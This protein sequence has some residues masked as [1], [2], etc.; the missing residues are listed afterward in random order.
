VL[1]LE[2]VF[3]EFLD[4]QDFALQFQRIVAAAAQAVYTPQFSYF[5]LV[6]VRDLH[7]DLLV[8]NKLPSI[9]GSVTPGAATPFYSL[10]SYAASVP[11]LLRQSSALVDAILKGAKPGD[12]PVQLPTI[13]DLAV[14]LDTARK[15]GVTIPTSILAQATLVIDYDIRATK[16]PN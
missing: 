14:N 12:L 8:R 2:P 3:V 5:N 9:G 7:F 16:A 1:G 10:I 13:F 4:G 11:H 15:I 6:S